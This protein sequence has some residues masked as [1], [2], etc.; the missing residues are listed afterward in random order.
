M[1]GILLAQASRMQASADGTML[2]AYSRPA[3]RYWMERRNPSRHLA[4]LPAQ[5]TKLADEFA[6]SSFAS[7]A[8]GA[9]MN[10]SPSR[11]PL[12]KHLVWETL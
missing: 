11:T 10:A 12:A 3:Q 6:D 4:A 5:I 8:R 7:G 2:T 9:A 1:L